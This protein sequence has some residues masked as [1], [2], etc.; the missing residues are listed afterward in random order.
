[1]SKRIVVTL[2]LTTVLCLTIVG[3]ALGYTSGSKSTYTQN[4][5][6]RLDLEMRY[7]WVNVDANFVGVQITEYRTKFTS[8]NS[9]Y[10][11]AY[12]TLVGGIKANGVATSSG[13]IV[14]RDAHNHQST[15]TV[16][17]SRAPTSG[18]WYSRYP[19]WNT[20]HLLAKASAVYYAYGRATG[21][22]YGKYT[23]KYIGTISCNVEYHGS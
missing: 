7:N 20:W 13:T 14:S 2:V 1:M 3:Q 16:P 15:W 21:Y 12:I 11:I 19:T 4:S 22:I 6:A 23:G 5:M 17:S 8:V 9:N 18:L 10:Y